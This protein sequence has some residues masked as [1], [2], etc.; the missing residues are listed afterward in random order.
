MNGIRRGREK[1]ALCLSGM[2]VFPEKE[3]FQQERG[4]KSTKMITDNRAL[5]KSWNLHVCK[6]FT[7][8]WIEKRVSFTD[9]GFQDCIRNYKLDNGTCTMNDLFS[10]KFMNLLWLCTSVQTSFEDGKRSKSSHRKHLKI[11]M[12]EGKYLLIFL[13]SKKKIACLRNAIK[14]VYSQRDKGI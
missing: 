7:F 14:M 10:F 1:N 9:T 3:L 4:K 12:G 6:N 13:C 2:W 5:P 11:Q 8:T